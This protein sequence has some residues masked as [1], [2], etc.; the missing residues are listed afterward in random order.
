MADTVSP[1]QRSEIMSR[2]KGKDTTPEMHVR[3][4]VHSMGYRYRLHRKHLPGRPD[5]VFASRKK[6]ILVH[7]CFW[8]QHDSP[9]CKI[10]SVPKSNRDYWLP[11][12]ARNVERDEENLKKLLELGWS[13]LVVWE[14]EVSREDLR[15]RLKRFLEFGSGAALAG[16]S[17]SA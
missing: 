16:T 5:L 11:K 17:A 12:L 7:G 14:C 10:V 2:I 4:L 3:R 8:H 9:E 6:I 1:E 13:V 15:K